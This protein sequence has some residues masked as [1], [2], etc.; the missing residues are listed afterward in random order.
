MPHHSSMESKPVGSPHHSSWQYQ[1]LNPLSKVRAQTQTLMDTSRG[2][3]LL[4]HNGNSSKSFETHL[5]L[6]FEVLAIGQHK[7]IGL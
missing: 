5:E 6:I 3:F 2:S 1:I 7:V 4:S